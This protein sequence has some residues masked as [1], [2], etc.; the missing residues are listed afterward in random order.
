M[1]G[2]GGALDRRQ[3]RRSGNLHSSL[4]RSRNDLQLRFISPTWHQ[5][6]FSKKFP[7]K[8]GFFFPCPQ[9][10]GKV[11]WRKAAFQVGIKPLGI[12]DGRSPPVEWPPSLARPDAQSSFVGFVFASLSRHLGIGVL[13]LT[14][15]C[16]PVAAIAPR[17]DMDCIWCCR[18]GCRFPSPPVS[19]RETGRSS[20]AHRAAGSCNSS[21]GFTWRGIE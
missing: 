15:C 18:T 13:P 10:K 4:M 21:S 14:T 17:T 19:R 8:K 6:P 12:A 20:K 16:D 2:G 9:K 7:Q 3:I 1:G 5:P 11:V